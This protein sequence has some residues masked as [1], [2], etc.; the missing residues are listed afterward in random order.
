MGLEAS[1]VI[2]VGTIVHQASRSLRIDAVR[3]FGRVFKCLDSQKR[4]TQQHRQ[5]Q[6]PFCFAGQI[7]FRIFQCDHDRHTGT[8]QHECVQGTNPLD[9]FYGLRRW[10]AAG[11]GP[12]PQNNVGSNQCREKHD[13]GR[14]EQPHR[15]LAGTN[16]NR[17]FVNQLYVLSVFGVV[18]SRIQGI[19]S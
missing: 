12:E 8:N 1:Q 17:R 4:Q 14:K 10:P 3:E 16:R 5:Q 15:Q 2:H 13:L 19:S 18:S 7:A 11:G 6:P 9:Q